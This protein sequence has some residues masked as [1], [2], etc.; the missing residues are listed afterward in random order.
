MLSWLRRRGERARRIEAEA[1]TLV[2]DYGVR[3][4]SVARQRQ[5]ESASIPMKQEW[6]RIARAVARNA[7]QRVGLDIGARMAIDADYEH[8][9]TPVTFDARAQLKEL[10]RILRKR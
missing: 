4:Y 2:R 1:D 9:R 7:H 3:A 5:R 6:S 8:G 10:E